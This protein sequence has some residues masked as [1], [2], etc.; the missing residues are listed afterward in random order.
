MRIDEGESCL[1]EASEEDKPWPSS[2]REPRERTREQHRHS[3]ALAIGSA[4]HECQLSMTRQSTEHK[5][6]SAFSRLCDTRGETTMSVGDDH[7]AAS[8]AFVM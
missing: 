3:E 4:R 6:R 2:Y 1:Q 8:E 7:T 5:K